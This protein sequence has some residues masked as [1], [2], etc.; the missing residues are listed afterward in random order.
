MEC[1]CRA[2]RFFRGAD[3]PRQWCASPADTPGGCFTSLTLI[4]A[5][6][7][8]SVFV[9]TVFKDMYVDDINNKV[10]LIDHYCRAVTITAAA[11]VSY[12]LMCMC[13]LV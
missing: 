13:T 7:I 8:T 12:I 3:E 2:L 11:A 5:T 9:C 10:L 1:F 6:I 4:H